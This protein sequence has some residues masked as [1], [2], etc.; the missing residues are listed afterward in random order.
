ML[1]IVPLNTSAYLTKTLKTT[2]K[3]SLNKTDSKTSPDI[4]GSTL[5]LDRG[6]CR[7]QKE[8]N[9]QVLGAACWIQELWEMVRL[10]NVSCLMYTLKLCSVLIWSCALEC[11]WLFHSCCPVHVSSAPRLCSTGQ[12]HSWVFFGDMF[13]D[14][15]VNLTPPLWVLRLILICGAW[16]KKKRKKSGEPLL[17]VWHQKITSPTR[18]SDILIT[19]GHTHDADGKMSPLKED[20]I[21]PNR[22]WN[23]L[24][25]RSLTNNAY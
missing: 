3:W 16:K 12:L 1:H 25:F 17:D 6:C 2:K 5:L 8:D 13:V 19:H 21:T 15:S 24:A 10:S 9:D 22:S 14:W 23:M 7:S 18:S 20:N 11:C 4:A